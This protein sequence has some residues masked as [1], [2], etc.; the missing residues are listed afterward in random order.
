[1]LTLDAML[2]A[3]A[4]LAYVGGTQANPEQ[5]FAEFKQMFGKAY[6][7]EAEEA[8]RFGIFKDNLAFVEAE[9]AKNHTY[10]LG[11]NKFADLTEEEFAT[12]YARGGAKP[13]SLFGDAP[14]LGFHESHGEDVPDSVDWRTKGV[15]TPVKNQEECGSCWSFA[16]T[17]AL[18][19]AWAIA[20]NKLVSLS[21]QQFVDC[22]TGD[23][24]CSGGL[25]GNAFKFATAN[26]LCTESSYPY[27]AKASG[28]CSANKCSVGI[29]E[30]KVTGYKGLAPVAR[31]IP[32]SESTMMSAVAKTPV[33]VAI[34]AD[35]RLFQ[36]YKG[37][38]LDGACGGG[39]DHGV[40]V[41][42]YGT[43][44]TGG[45]YWLIKN[46]WGTD[47][48]ENGYWR[49]KRGKSYARTGECGILSS[50]SYP[51][52]GDSDTVIV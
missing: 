47:H 46:S 34:E 35:K 11:V 25:P 19:A 1:M 7:S 15:L 38:V 12:R 37:G 33:A 10:E 48:G 23:M 2:R 9:N 5:A 17:G 26:A 44:P 31:I 40:L 41:A 30:G 29:P 32:A 6:S 39:V 27:L 43:D 51:I 50:P 42:G 45:D 28:T 3:A 36:L 24:G 21:E 52:I 8:H 14:F 49:I 18:E 13:E 22:D 20:G 16:A 4:F